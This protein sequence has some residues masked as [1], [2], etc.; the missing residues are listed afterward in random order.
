MPI[1]SSI[2]DLDTNPNN[3]SPQGS[4]NV[5]PN[6]NGYIQALGAFI[7]QLATGAGLKPTATV[8]FNAQKITNLLAGSTTSTSTDALNGAQV[9]ALSYKVG[10][11]RMWH[12]LTS[13][14]GI[15]NVWGPGWQLA[16]GTNGTAN[17][18]DRFVVA[19]GAFYTVG[20]TGG[21]STQALS[22]ANLPAHNHGVT[23]PGH[24]HAISD[25]G[26]L[27]GYTDPG[28]NHTSSAGTNFIAAGGAGVVNF[29]G[30]SLAIQ[31]AASTSLAVTGISINTNVTGISVANH[32][33]GITTNNAGSG[34]P[35]DTRPLYYALAFIEYTGIGA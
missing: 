20:A 32:T 2:N 18:V 16:D 9:R 21:S 1:P 22:I 33:T 34:T 27:H 35:I 24:I 23:D 14:A 31:A 29:G 15:T 10:E 11:V 5:G 7:K 12:G 8:D 28:H 3:N 4:E 6:A 25:P 17:L 30:S 19:A 26:H 13:Q